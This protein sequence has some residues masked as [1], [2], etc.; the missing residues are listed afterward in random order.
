MRVE[1]RRADGA[2][3]VLLG[4]GLAVIMRGTQVTKALDEDVLRKMGPW[5]PVAST[6]QLRRTIEKEVDRC[7]V[8]PVNQMVMQFAEPKPPVANA[9]EL[10]AKAAEHQAKAWGEENDLE[11]MQEDADEQ[12]KEALRMS[13]SAKTAD[14]HRK[15]AE[16]LEAASAA[17]E[18]VAKLKTPAG[19]VPAPGSPEF[20]AYVDAEVAKRVAGETARTEAEQA[21]VAAPVA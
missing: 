20:Q 14:E 21:T 10:K 18:A 4:A 1:G 17:Q 16:A 9:E 3:L 12:A 7:R 11:K 6:L 15:A 13:S 5:E 8:V 2:Q 19:G